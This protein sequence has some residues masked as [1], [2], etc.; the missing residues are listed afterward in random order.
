MVHS[1]GDTQTKRVFKGRCSELRGSASPLHMWYKV[2]PARGTKD[3]VTGTMGCRVTGRANNITGGREN[4][5]PPSSQITD[6]I[7]NTGADFFMIC[8]GVEV[9]LPSVISLSFA[10]W[11][12]G[13]IGQVSEV[14]SGE[15]VSLSLCELVLDSS[16]NSST[17]PLSAVSTFIPPVRTK[18]HLIKVKSGWRQQE[19]GCGVYW[20]F[21]C[22][23][24]S[25]PSQAD[26]CSASGCIISFFTSEKSPGLIRCLTF[27]RCNINGTN[28][29]YGLYK[30]EGM[31]QQTSHKIKKFY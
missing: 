26:V 8:A 28:L 14:A 11:T 29:H 17:V 24:R 2:A 12:E 10:H 25:S 19:A 21:L 5:S 16:C 9:M 1:G 27:H 3:Q 20:V 23:T 18:D 22:W 6:A 31:T 15:I 4:T 7:L 13:T 30:K